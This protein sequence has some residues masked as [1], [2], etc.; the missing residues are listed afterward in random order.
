MNVFFVS[1]HDDATKESD[2]AVSASVAATTEYQQAKKVSPCGD[3]VLSCLSMVPIRREPVDL[4][5]WS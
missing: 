4:F 3:S 1:Q 2:L 5:S